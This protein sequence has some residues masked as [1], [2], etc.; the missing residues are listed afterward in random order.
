MAQ[1]QAFNR[2][3]QRAEMAHRLEE[4]VS[5][6]AQRARQLANERPLL[7]VTAAVVAGYCLGRI[8]SRV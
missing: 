8:A 2:S 1:T 7:A 3:T 5:Q 4:E 6:V